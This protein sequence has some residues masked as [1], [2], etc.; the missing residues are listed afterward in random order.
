MER[1]IAH[2]DVATEHS[3]DTVRLLELYR[4]QGW[5]T[6]LDTGALIVKVPGDAAP[7]LNRVAAQNGI[8]LRTLSPRE[9]TLED[10]FL[11]MTGST[12]GDNALF[13]SRQKN[14]KRLGLRRR[15]R[16]TAKEAS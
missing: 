10:V 11:E 13:R 3:E 1:A 6:E 2:V 16:E 8:T 5:E 12:D 7:E 15:T 14:K 4:G 9:D